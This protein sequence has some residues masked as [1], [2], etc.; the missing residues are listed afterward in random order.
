MV[1][2]HLAKPYVALMVILFGL[3]LVCIAVFLVS[4]L[5]PASGEFS[6]YAKQFGKISSYQESNELR[7]KRIYDDLRRATPINFVGRDKTNKPCQSLDASHSQDNYA[8]VYY[9]T[10][11]YQ[12]PDKNALG[13]VG[14]EEEPPDSISSL[15]AR[16]KVG[17]KYICAAIE[18]LGSGIP[19]EPSTGPSTKI[20]FYYA[21]AGS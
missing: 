8:V 4:K 1:K 14:W 5:I 21:P 2:Q 3:L 15:I 12:N 7:Q 17:D 13:P 9:E 16:K 20:I 18:P 10:L 19:E 6:G 11:D